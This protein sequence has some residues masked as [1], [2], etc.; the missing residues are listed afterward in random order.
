MTVLPTFL[1]TVLQLVPGGEQREGQ[2]EEEEEEEEE[3]GWGRKMGE[4]K[5]VGEE[6][7]RKGGKGEAECINT[8]SISLADSCARE[9]GRE[10]GEGR[11]ETR[12]QG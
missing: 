8:I 3:E 7:G 11:T 10:G 9:G 6:R 4:R 12:P 5:R 1:V 2:E